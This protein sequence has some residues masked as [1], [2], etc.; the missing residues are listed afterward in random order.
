VLPE[1]IKDE[2]IKNT[3][4]GISVGTDISLDIFDLFNNNDLVITQSLGIAKEEIANL[5]RTFKATA[6]EI[7]SV[8]AAELNQAFFDMVMGPD[9][10]TSK[11][12]FEA[13]IKENL[14]IYYQGEAERQLEAEI[15]ALLEKKHKF[16]LPDTFLKRW[17]QETKPSTYNAETV[18]SLYAKESIVLRKQLIR[19]KVADVHHVEVSD[20]DINQA[21]FAYTAQMLRQYGLNNPD[22]AM[23]Q[24]F[25]AKNREEKSY[26]LRIRDVVVE[27][28]VLNA[29]KEVITI[30]IKPIAIDKFYD[31]V[32]DFND[33]G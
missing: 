11:E 10:C 28:K 9:V 18:D 33:Q 13:K 5:N 32:K 17:L 26:L 29:V 16:T 4:V 15:N 8:V 14:E 23:V 6:K 30:D 20:D 21:S 3:L 22:P 24:N 1:V 12:E 2:K 19:E 25:E 7:R 31:M 27:K